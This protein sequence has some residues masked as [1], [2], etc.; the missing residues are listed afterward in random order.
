[1]ASVASEWGCHLASCSVEQKN[2]IPVFSKDPK[3]ST[4][5]GMADNAISFGQ[6]WCLISEVQE[7]LE[8][9]D[10]PHGYVSSHSETEWMVAIL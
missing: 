6:G 8:C 3:G 9:P 5:S 7:R 1:M 10:N 2:C 4:D